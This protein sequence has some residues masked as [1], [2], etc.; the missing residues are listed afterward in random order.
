MQWQRRWRRLVKPV[1]VVLAGLIA[2]VMLGEAPSLWAQGASDTLIVAVGGDIQ[3]ID[4][5]VTSGAPFQHEIITNLYDFLIDFGLRQTDSGETV[6]DLN[7]FTG[8]VAKAWTVSQDGTVTFRLRENARF[9]DGTPVTAEAVKYSYERIF[10]VN[11]VTAALMRMASVPD[12]SHLSMVDAHAVTMKMDKPNGLLFGNMSQFGHAIVN[13]AQ[14]KPH[15]GAQDPWSR[16]WLKTHAAGAGPFMLE[17][18]VPGSEIVLAR[19][20][21]YWAGPAKLARIDFKIV[22]DASTR[23][24]LLRRGSVDI[25]MDLAFQD[26][27]RLKTDRSVVV[28]DFPTTIV[29]YIGMNVNVKPFDN[30]KVRQA[31]AYAVPYDTI[32]KEVVK[33]FGRPLR[34]PVPAGMPS[35]VDAAAMY[36]TN[37]Q[38]ARQLLAE[39]GLAGG[40]KTKLTVRAGFPTD[41]QI[42]VWVQSA[43]RPVGI[44]VEIEKLPLAGYTERLLKHDL[45][46]F[47]HEW[48]SINN[49]PFYHYFWL[50]KP[51]CCNYGNYQNAAITEQ[52]ATNLLSTNTVTR[53]QSSQQLQKTIADDA[54]WVFLYQPDYVI[55]MRKG[56][57]G[58][59]YYP[60]RYNRYFTVHKE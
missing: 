27:E 48:L 47:L 53:N 24:L 43:L 60:D 3:T 37:Q 33:G 12:A 54:P 9:A 50:F 34:S 57:K 29:R 41:E 6:G 46:F 10:G 11:A 13:P 55:A 56:V 19:N 23:A 52:L 42:A 49:D 32:M 4:P 58:F 40:F 7:R 44:D 18:W 30:V 26:L 59:I 1:T 45:A 2:L 39:A 38:R 28:R 36:A 25:A 51:G 17:R 5:P 35:H 16:D 31:V 8:K 14:V 21:H 22:P 20:P 15:A